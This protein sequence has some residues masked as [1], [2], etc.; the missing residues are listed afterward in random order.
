MNAPQF[1]YFP[2]AESGCAQILQ[3]VVSW[4]LRARD[5]N[6]RK[7]GLPRFLTLRVLEVIEYRIDYDATEIL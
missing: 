6:V 5:C 1:S 7:P 2:R 3:R 4:L